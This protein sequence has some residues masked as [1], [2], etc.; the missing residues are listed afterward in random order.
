MKTKSIHGIELLRLFAIF[1]VVFIHS[2]REYERVVE[3]NIAY[4]IL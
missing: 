4:L 3:E 2:T 1:M